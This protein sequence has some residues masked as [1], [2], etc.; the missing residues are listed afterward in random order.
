MI[1]N[2]TDIWHNIL[3]TLETRRIAYTLWRIFGVVF[4]IEE[5]SGMLITKIE[6]KDNIKIGYITHENELEAVQNLSS[7]EWARPE[8]HNAWKAVENAALR[9]FW[10]ENEYN[11]IDL[12]LE[13][14]EISYTKP[15]RIVQ[16]FNFS[17]YMTINRVTF[18]CK[19]K[20]VL[21][22]NDEALTRAVYNMATEAKKYIKGIRAQQSLWE[23]IG[24]Y[25]DMEDIPTNT[26]SLPQPMSGQSL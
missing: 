17:G 21:P 13:R 20:G 6:T 26:E 8:F 19:L 18:N 25:Q 10:Q 15:P 1:K 16:L 11:E 4:F 2:V 9:Y 7:K 23:P 22:G 5:G 3:L 12:L 14:I 24:N